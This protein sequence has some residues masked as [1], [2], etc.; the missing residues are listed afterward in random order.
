LSW[1]SFGISFIYFDILGLALSI[2]GLLGFVLS[3]LGLLG[4]SLISFGLFDGG[5]C[6]LELVIFV[7]VFWRRT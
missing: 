3:L 2:L 1:S 4:V 6:S 7:R 5:P